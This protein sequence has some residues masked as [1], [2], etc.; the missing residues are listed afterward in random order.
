MGRPMI[1][2]LL[3]SGYT[4]QVYDQ[5]LEASQTVIEVGAVWCDSPRKAAQDADIVMTNLPL[6]H[7]VQE[8]ILGENGALRAMKPG[9][10]WIDFSTTDYH[11]TR[12]IANEAKKKCVYSLDAPVSN[13]SHMGIDFGNVSFYVS[14]DREGFDFCQPVLNEIGKISFFV[15]NQIGQ[16]QGV[17]LLTN[18]LCYTAIV[19]VGEVLV[20]AKKYNIPLDWM[21]EFI[22]ASQGNSF[23]AEQITPFILDGSYDHSCSLQMAVKDTDLT[24]KLADELGIVLPLAKIIA[25]RYQQAG[26]K[27]QLSDNYIIVTQL[28]EENNNLKLR[29]PSFTAPSP[30]GINPD[31]TY[32]DEFLKDNLGRVKPHPYQ[33]D[34]HRPQ[35]KLDDDL[36][37][38]AQT[39]TQL[40]A[41]INYLVLQEAYWLGYRIGINRDLLLDVIR[42]GC[43]SS[44][45]SE[46]QSVYDPD[47]R[48]VEKIKIYS[49]GKGIKLDAIDQIFNV[50]EKQK[51]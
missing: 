45:V 34:Y 17:K 48:I 15:L 39:L 50:I 44:W 29:I 25:G 12:H 3:K 20:V 26:E 4:V 23:A 2:K 13:L 24:L 6:P 31:Y 19:I 41:Y 8:N 28:A 11:N 33:F 18:L 46:N 47:D 40:M 16:A 10:T 42:W 37:D 30:Y 1:F 5:S 7:H 27:Y 32:P 38:L 35:Q 21:W 9:S 36:E 49:N 22:K 51:Q 43:G 14:G